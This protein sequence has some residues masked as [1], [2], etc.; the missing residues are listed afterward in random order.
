VHTP[1]LAHTVDLAR[2]AGLVHRKSTTKPKCAH[3]AKAHAKRGFN[4]KIKL[5]GAYIRRKKQK[6]KTHRVSELSSEEIQV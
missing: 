2:A 4:V 1:D 6:G 5:L 3:S